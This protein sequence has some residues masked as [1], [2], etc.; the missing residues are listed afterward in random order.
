MKKG[1]LPCFSGWPCAADSPSAL[2]Q[3]GPL[4]LC[5]SLH[6]PPALRPRITQGWKCRAFSEPESRPSHA[7]MCGF[8]NSQSFRMPFLPKEMFSP[9]FVPGFQSSLACVHCNLLPQVTASCSFLDYTHTHTHMYII[10]KIILKF[11]FNYSWYTILYEFQVYNIVIR[12]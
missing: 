9:T 7:C 4:Q 5:L 1:K 2:R 11:T 12:R 3:V 8:P 6:I 10:L